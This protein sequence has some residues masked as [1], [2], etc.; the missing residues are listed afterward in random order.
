VTVFFSKD[1][2][3]LYSTSIGKTRR[4]NRLFN[5]SLHRRR[6]WCVLGNTV[7]RVARLVSDMAGRVV[8][9]TDDVRITPRIP[10]TDAQSPNTTLIVL[11]DER[12]R[13]FNGIL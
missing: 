12:L 6:G 7:P 8:D 2:T 11:S 4:K 13:D 9:I 10:S 1:S 5:H 3:E